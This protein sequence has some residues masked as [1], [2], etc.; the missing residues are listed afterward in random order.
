M[1]EEFIRSNDV[2]AR[3]LFAGVGGIGSEIVTKVAEMCRA[4]ETENVNFVCMDT[5]AN[6]LRAVKDS[7][8]NIYYV[9]TSSTQTVG[10]YLNYDKDAMDNWFKR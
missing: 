6:D 1:R 10:D 3:T 9:Q 2:M 8:T 7:A 4:G 5:N